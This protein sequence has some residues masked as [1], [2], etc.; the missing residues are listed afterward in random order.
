MWNYL[1]KV[2]V[3]N[4]FWYLFSF[5]IWTLNWIVHQILYIYLIYHLN[6][7]SY[8]IIKYNFIQY[9]SES[10]GESCIA[11]FHSIKFSRYN[12]FKL[13]PY[14][15]YFALYR[16]ND[17]NPFHQLRWRMSGEKGWVWKR[18]LRFSSFKGQSLVV[19]NNEEHLW[20]C[21]DQVYEGFPR[22]AVDHLTWMRGRQLDACVETY[23]LVMFLL[24]SCRIR[25]EN[26]VVIWYK[27]VVC[28]YM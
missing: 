14:C 1:Y 26:L 6:D 9:S 28:C 18:E 27:I 24:F 3:I 7:N 13:H 2:N 23:E 8:F 16:T 4:L 10:Q 19:K 21:Y 5:S 20:Q 17:H 11:I 22:N 25:R 12:I 15:I